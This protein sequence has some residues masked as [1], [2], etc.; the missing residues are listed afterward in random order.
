[1]RQSAAFLF[2]SRISV[3][4][5]CALVLALAPARSGRAQAAPDPHAVQPERPT[6]ATHAGTVAPGWLEIETGVEVDGLQSAGSSLGIPTVFKLGLAPRVQLNLLLPAARPVGGGLGVGDVGVGVKWRA[7]Q[8]APIL[9][10]FAILPFVKFPTGSTPASQGTGTTDFSILLISSRTVGP[11]AID[12]NLGYTI[13]SGNGAAAPTHS[14]LWTASVG[15]PLL[16]RLGAVTEIYGYPAT[17]GP[18][19]MESIVALL[20]GPTFLVRPWLALDA[21]VIVPITGPQPHAVYAG[22][23]WNVGRVWKTRTNGRPTR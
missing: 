6:V 15:Y 9:G 18:A 23:V 8:D 12:L 1:M 22:G 11:V 2:H 17:S 4:A 3:G 14:A 20:A 21:G 13:R 16:G 5:W 10:D 19:G 7:L